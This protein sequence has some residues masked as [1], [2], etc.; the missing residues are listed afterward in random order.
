M[1]SSRDAAATPPSLTVPALSAPPDV[2]FVRDYAI[3][4]YGGIDMTTQYDTK[5]SL[6]SL[7]LAELHKMPEMRSVS[8]ISIYHLPLGT[9]ENGANWIV[10]GFKSGAANQISVVR[11]LRP[12]VTA[13]QRRHPIV[14]D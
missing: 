12:I 1:P 11:A 10:A 4:T 6:C 13:V 7:L 2:V 3:W 8:N 14:R 5:D 9:K